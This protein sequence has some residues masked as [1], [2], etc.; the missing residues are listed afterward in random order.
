MFLVLHNEFNSISDDVKVTRYAKVISAMQLGSFS[1]K[2]FANELKISH[3]DCKTN[4]L[5]SSDGCG[6]FLK[7]QVS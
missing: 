6:E 1:I 7:I 3:C 5:A 4:H 2:I